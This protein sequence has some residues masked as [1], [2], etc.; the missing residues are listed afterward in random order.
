MNIN[1]YTIKSQEA[2]QSAVELARKGGNQAIEPAHLL[3]SL[4][5][6]GDSLTDF[7]LSKLAIQRPRLEDAV[8]KQLS[9]LPKVS[10]G[11]PYLSQETNKILDKA[12]DLATEMSPWSTSSSP[13]SRWTILW[14]AS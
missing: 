12:E 14:H 4:L 3:E 11:E 8:K 13:S 1:K 6:L 9:S 7:L 10:G 2:L 5:S